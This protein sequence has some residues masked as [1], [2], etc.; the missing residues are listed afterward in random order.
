MQIEKEKVVSVTYNLSVDGFD[1]KSVKQVDKER[2]LTFHYGVG[3]MLEKFEENL[4]GFKS[5]DTFEFQI[6]SEDAY[7]QASDEA[8]VD[9][10]INIFEIEGKID[11]DLLKVGNYI[12]MQDQEG[13]KLDGIVLEVGDEQVK[14][15]FN[16]PLAGDDLYFKG[17]VIDVREATDEEKQQGHANTSQQQQQ[18]QQ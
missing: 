11:Y 2:P 18:Q 10:P 4:E 8:I 16:H 1:V 14:M 3:N 6:K 9:L 12:P 17:E 7:G 5:G 13:N 15:D